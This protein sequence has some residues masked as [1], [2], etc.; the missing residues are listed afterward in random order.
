MK[1]SPTLS[2]RRSFILAVFFLLFLPTAVAFA[3]TGVDSLTPDEKNNISVFQQTNKSVVNVTNS[4]IQKDFFTL[5]IYE[6]PAG[7]GTGFVWD[8]SGL[9]VTNYHVIEN[10]SKIKITLWDQ[11]NWDGKVVG[12][13][14]HKDLA[15]IKIEA[16]ADKLF[17]ITTGDSN[18]LDV[19]RK[20]LAIG[21]PFGLDTT[22][23][24]G[25]VSALGRE[26][27]AGGRRI[28]DLIQ[29]DAA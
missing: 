5:N 2:S 11:S 19:G 10:A 6:I 29:T 18:K 12:T 21:N 16:P 7:A 20:V 17:P 8:R 1:T 28:K 25:V 22:L 3:D 26:I 27:E 24:I 4:Q 23:T 9:I 13:A 15:V 14:P